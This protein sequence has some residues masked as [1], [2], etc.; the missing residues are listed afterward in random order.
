MVSTI[1]VILTTVFFNS[2]YDGELC[3]SVEIVFVLVEIF[4]YKYKF[5]VIHRFDSVS[6]VIL[7]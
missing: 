1:A 4:Y 3:I 2:F 6:V 7:S 5:V